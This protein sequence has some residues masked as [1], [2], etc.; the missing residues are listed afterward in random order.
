[1]DK[2][3][4]TKATPPCMPNMPVLINIQLH[5]NAKTSVDSTVIGVDTDQKTALLPCHCCLYSRNIDNRVYRAYAKGVSVN[6][7]PAAFNGL[8]GA[9]IGQLSVRP[10]RMHV[11]PLRVY[12]PV[13]TKT[14]RY[15]WCAIS[16]SEQAALAMS[17]TSATDIPVSFKMSSNSASYSWPYRSRHAF[18]YKE[19]SSASI[20]RRR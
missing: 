4:Q 11:T 12:S 15:L 13:A 3:P 5:I 17:N 10:K 8:A 7:S 19:S 18:G 20:L 1:M 6:K 16:R 2:T 9:Q 14:L